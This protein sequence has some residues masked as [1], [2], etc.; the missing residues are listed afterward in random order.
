MT[1]IEQ[2]KIVHVAAV[3]L[4]LAINVNSQIVTPWFTSGD[5][6]ML[7]QQQSSQSFGANTVSA[8]V[9]IAVDPTTT[10][11]AMD[12][13]G[14]C[15]TEGS[16]E[17]ISSL[18]YTEQVSLLNELFN[19]TT[20][21]GISMLRISIGA[22]DLSSSD[23]SYDETSGDMTMANFSLTGP[24]LTYLIPVLKKV[25]A[26]NPDI[27][28][29]A[30]PWSAPRWMKSNGSWIGGS[31]NTTSYAAYAAYFVKYLDAMKAQGISIWAI[32]PQNEPE[33]AGNEPS[34]L[35]S[36]TEEKNFINNNLGPVMTGAGYQAVKIIAYD[37]N[38]NDTAYPIDVL[39]N[40]TY[41]DGAAFHLY[42][43]DI[44]ALTTV[45]NATGK[46]V[47]FTEQYT[48]STGSFS[49]DLGWHMQNIILGAANNWAKAILEWNI[50][51]NANFGPHTSG[52]CTDCQGAITI[53][54]NISYTRNLSYYL[55]GH[56]S[57]FVLSGAIRIRSSSS[58]SKV[59]VT[60]Y[61]NPDGSLVVLAYN[62]N[63]SSQI[64][65]IVW[66][67]QVAVFTLPSSTA[68][69]FSWNPTAS[70][71]TEIPVNQITLSPNPGHNV[72]TLK[73]PQNG[74]N[75]TTIRFITVDGKTALTKTISKQN[76]END[77]DVS[78]LSDGI[79][80][81]RVD[82]LNNNLVGRFIKQ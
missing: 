72:V 7:L 6:T 15:L 78:G 69:T 46:N 66:N 64:V 27:K 40:S 68:A 51:N 42:S 18:N 52:G 28:I 13:F 75:Y 58:S 79:Y 61:E 3:F 20:G 74:F 80:L 14:Y 44:S 24:D 2:K 17:V 5:K 36:S 19:K 33:N 34:M 53:N 9:N 8:N 37:H 63:S 25:L 76:L 30:T 43:G 1:R 55:I 10:F 22:S 54:S 4:F 35:M 38:C 50:A 67:S 73:L 62:S 29:L 60:A 59:P 32:T 39:N 56:I 11:Q 21:L 16:A 45:W 12:G 41:V 57:K 81:I 49:G 23:Y 70:A 47:Y 65:K 26:I 82:G 77:I 48:A 71:V 31:L